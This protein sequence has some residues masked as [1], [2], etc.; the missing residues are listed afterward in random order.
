ML[1]ISQKPIFVIDMRY[2]LLL[3]FLLPFYAPAQ[4]LEKLPSPNNQDISARFDLLARF[5]H[6]NFFSPDTSVNHYL[7]T[8]LNIIGHSV[9]YENNAD[10]IKQAK[11]EV[12]QI[13]RKGDEI[14]DFKKYQLDGPPLIDSIAVDIKDQQ[15]F[16][17]EP[18]RYTIDVVMKDLNLKAPKEKKSSLNIEVQ[19]LSRGTQ[20]SDVEMLESVFETKEKNNLSKSGFDCVPLIDNFYAPEMNKIAFYTEIYNTHRTVGSN[21]RFLLKV[22]VEKY[23]DMSP[24][25]EFAAMQKLNT[26]PVVP[27]IQVLDITDL[28]TGKYNLILT[29]INRSNETMLRKKVFFQRMNTKNIEDLAQIE[30]KSTFVNQ[31]TSEDTLNMFIA[32]TRPITSAQ[33]KRIMDNHMD[34]FDMMT[35][36]QYFYNFWKSRNPDNP[37]ESWNL[38]LKE[39][40]LVQELYSTRIKQGFETDRGR[41]YLAYGKPDYVESRP[42]EPSS[43]PY[44]MWQYYRIKQFNNRNFIFYMPDLVTN[45]YQLLH[46]DMQGEVANYRWQND[47]EKRNTPFQDIDQGSGRDHYGGNSSIIFDRSK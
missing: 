22:S 37:E 18:G 12:T 31:I 6:A 9:K 19:D 27:V 33:E 4:N 29:L 24:M 17:V 44:E 43:Y 26:A 35:K 34:E 23:E 30:I 5:E 45:D 38:Y 10:G 28:Q 15:R 47:L 13:L 3:P 7:E 32:C 1:S 11:I 16:L 21:E 41:I 40:R 20:M 42:N 8:Y 25:S 14:I 2:L 39:V 46:S 36:Q